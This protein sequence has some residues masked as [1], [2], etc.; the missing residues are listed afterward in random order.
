MGQIPIHLLSDSTTIHIHQKPKPFKIKIQSNIANAEVWVDHMLLGKTPLSNG[1][2]DGSNRSSSIVLVKGNLRSAPTNIFVHP[3]GDTS[4][5]LELLPGV[6]I[7]NELY[8]VVRVNQKLW[9]ARDISTETPNRITQI[10]NDSLNSSGCIS[11]LSLYSALEATSLCP[12]GWSIP[13]KEN[14]TELLEAVN[15]SAHHLFA[16]SKMTPAIN[17]FDMLGFQSIPTGG[18]HSGKSFYGPLSVYWSRGY[19]NELQAFLLDSLNSKTISIDDTVNTKF[20]LR[21]IQNNADGSDNQISIRRGNFLMG[22]EQGEADETPIHKVQISDF[23]LDSYEV[24]QGHF[25]QVMEFNPSKFNECGLNC[26]VENV[27]WW[28]A[29]DYCQKVQK[30]L[31]SEA[32][33]EYVAK[34]VLKDSS[35]CKADSIC[36]NTA[37]TSL[38]SVG[39]TH[40]IGSFPVDTL[41]FWDLIGNVNEWTNDIYDSTYYQSSEPSNP[42]G[43]KSG[44]DRVFKG[45][46]WQSKSFYTRPANRGFIAS[47]TRVSSIGFRCAD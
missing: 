30:R 38:N 18:I 15:D 20:A 11:S 27:D 35:Q 21:C 7:H 8:P 36:I 22:S 10:C 43:A 33:W 16:K 37:W 44:D 40:P 4:L 41:G 26:P 42:K 6:R 25:L 5:S 17:D 19:R 29:K 45:G 47:N 28:N 46:S 24:T 13:T 14:W 2:I 1:Q 9:M 39:T 32:E 31:P 23:H 3:N 34:L 12:L